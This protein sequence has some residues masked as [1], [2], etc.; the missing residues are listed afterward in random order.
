MIPMSMRKE[1]EGYYNYYTDIHTYVILIAYSPQDVR[2][3]RT[4]FPDS[5]ST[6][7]AMTPSAPGTRIG[8]DQDDNG[9]GNGNYATP[10]GKV[11]TVLIIEKT[12][13]S[14]KKTYNI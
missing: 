4:R 9:I 10:S 11:R 5:S 8:S 6:S 7:A 3:E 14:S 2:D 12:F 1:L 13:F